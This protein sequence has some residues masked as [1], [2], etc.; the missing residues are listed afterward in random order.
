[1]R[2]NGNPNTI[3]LI[4]LYPDTKFPFM[5]E[6]LGICAISGYLQDKHGE[7][8]T[9]KMFDQQLNSENEIIS[10]ILADRPAIIGI[11]IKV[12]SFSKFVQFYELL[13]SEAFSVYIPLIVIGNSV[14]HFSG[15]SILREYGF[16]DVI[17]SLG[18]GEVS[19]SDLYKYVCGKI[20]LEEVNNIMYCQNGNIRRTPF[21]YLDKGEIPIADRRFTQD[22]YSKDG[23]IYIE[24]SR[25]CAYCSCSICECRYFLGSTNS[26][27]KWRDKPIDKVVEEML[28]LERLGVKAVNFS[29]EDFI[30]PDIYGIRRTVDLATALINRGIN[31][32]FR[33]NARVRSIYCQKDTPEITQNK[34]EMLN[35]LKQA[36]LVKLFLGFESGVQSQIDRY[37]KGYKLQEFIEAKKILDELDIEYEL[38]YITID[39]LMTLEE[40]YESLLF[41]KNNGCIPHISSI[42]KELRIQ[43]GNRTYLERLRQYECQTGKSLV[44]NI[45]FDEQRY[46]IIGYVDDRIATIVMIM[47]DYISENYKKYYEL[48]RMTQYDENLSKHDAYTVIEKLRYNDYDLLLKLTESL[49]KGENISIQYEILD[50]HKRVRDKLLSNRENETFVNS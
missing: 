13:K 43:K 35:I 47:K 39:P 23:E 4:A 41:I 42:Y 26:T 18:E 30:G 5:G 50:M 1:M 6:S 40:L 46:D 34:K 45:L 2:T 8:L 44:G 21:R 37:G 15:E 12:F 31:I 29:D 19:F 17:V 20:L 49:M 28:M 3:Y 36:G 24:A 48:R 38:G 11:S 22:F 32:S 16:P 10:H 14:A 33:I 27:Y 9:I 25:G 7:S